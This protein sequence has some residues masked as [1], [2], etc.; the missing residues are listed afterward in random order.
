MTL[1]RKCPSCKE[2][3]GAESVVCPRC[4]VN[5]TAA[6]IRRLVIWILTTALVLWCRRPFRIEGRVASPAK[7]P[8]IWCSACLYGTVAGAARPRFQ[9]R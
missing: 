6:R 7:L 4:G 1:D 8:L 9:P 2:I 3:V 5:F